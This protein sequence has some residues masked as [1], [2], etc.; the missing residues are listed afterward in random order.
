M[1]RNAVQ[2]ISFEIF[3]RRRRRIFFL[4]SFPVPLSFFFLENKSYISSNIL[5]VF[6]SLSK[7]SSLGL[8]SLF[9]SFES[10]PCRSRLKVF[11]PFFFSLSV[12]FGLYAQATGARDFKQFESTRK[13]SGLKNNIYNGDTNIM[14][15]CDAYVYVRFDRVT[16]SVCIAF[17]RQSV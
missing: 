14:R 17:Y 11:L 7:V 2:R 13:Q 9:F 12:S 10:R 4:L 1:S 5:A 16:P 15:S 8:H 3:L 6:R